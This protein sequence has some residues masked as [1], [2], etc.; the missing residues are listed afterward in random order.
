VGLIA[1]GPGGL[2]R[3][4]VVSAVLLAAGALLACGQRPLPRTA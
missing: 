2:A 4:F 3:G 1:D